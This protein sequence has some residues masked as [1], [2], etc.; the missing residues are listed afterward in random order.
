MPSFGTRSQR[1]LDSCHPYL[2]LILNKAIQ[3][4]DFSVLRGHSSKKEQLELFKKGRKKTGGEWV[5]INKSAIV[6]NCDGY[7]K[8]SRHNYKPSMAVDIAPYPINWADTERFRELSYIIKVIAGMY[9][10]RITWGGD[11]KKFKDM[12]H[13]E[14]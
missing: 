6:T 12:P 7:K 8:I 2:Q 11:W 13:Y 4:Y 9:G 14:L 1:N 10:I 5:I 3:Y